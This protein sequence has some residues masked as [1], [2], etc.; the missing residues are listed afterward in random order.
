MPQEGIEWKPHENILTFEEI[1]RI[2]K[3]MAELGVKNI[4]VTGGEP[5]LRKGTLPFL[6]ELKNIPKIENI[7]LTTNG[8]LL[9]EYLEK[10][11]KLDYEFLP[12]GINISIDSLNSERYKKITRYENIDPLMIISNIERLLKLNI[13][14]KINCVPIKSINE[15]D[16][17]PLVSLAKDKNITIR[18]IELMPIKYAKN[19]K[20]IPG[21]DTAALIEQTFGILTPFS[22]SL[23]NGPAIYYSL[24]GFSGKVGFINPMTQCFCKTCNRLR[25]TSEGFLKL[26]LSGNLGLDLR[27]MMR[28][29]VSDSEISKAVTE[30]VKQK[31]L[32][33]SFKN[34]SLHGMSE[35]GG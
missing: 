25:L 4:K 33:H 35:I 1:L 15:K 28:E 19:Y 16:I 30:I 26:C 14:V 11:E 27:K 24:P 3:I 8:I 23:G 22:A 17:I 7:T 20:A 12:N 5:L 29:S 18:F 34:Q 2:I 9:G 6:K 31:P 10:I 13:K 32:S 21:T